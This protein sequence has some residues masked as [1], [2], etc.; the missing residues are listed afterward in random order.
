[1]NTEKSCRNSTAVNPEFSGYNSRLAVESKAVLMSIFCFCD[2][3]SATQL[4]L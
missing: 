4:N 2:N 3:L 1:M